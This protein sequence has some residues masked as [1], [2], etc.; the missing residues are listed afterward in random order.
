MML[1][2]ITVGLF[3]FLGLSF[4]TTNKILGWALLCLATL[5]LVVWLRVLGRVLAR[6]A[7]QEA[8]SEPPVE[9]APW[10]ED[11]EESS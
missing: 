11:E 6:R 4:L 7:N 5:R 9:P 1:G 3:L 8:S 2:L 10:P